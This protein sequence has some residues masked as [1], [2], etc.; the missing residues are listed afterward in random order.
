MDANK[1]QVIQNWPQPKNVK[2]LQ[3]FLGSV[4]YLSK[5]IP[6]L[7]S[8]RKPLQDLLKSSNKFVWL[9]VYGKAFKTLKNAIMKDVMLKYFDLN[10]PI[11]IETNTLKK[12]IGVVIIQPDNSVE[13]TSRT[14][15]PNNLR[16]VFYASKTLT[17]TES[18]YSNIECEMLGVVFS[19]LHFKHFMYGRQCT[20]SQIINLSSR[21][22]LKI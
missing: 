14:E 9:K 20:S 6:H 7:S 4:N 8:F 2:E 1:W 11:Y 16:P 13:N 18:N 17:A 19:M 3:S 22:L 10:L 15:V 12:G 5:F 21:C